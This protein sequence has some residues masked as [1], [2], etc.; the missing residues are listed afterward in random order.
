M[1]VAERKE[2]SL[3]VLGSWRE[4]FIFLFL[5]DGNYNKLGISGSV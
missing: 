2:G 5:V 3:C 1:F 4:E